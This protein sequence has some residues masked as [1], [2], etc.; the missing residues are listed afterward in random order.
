MATIAASGPLSFSTIKSIM[1]GPATTAIS[2][3]T[4]FAD[5]KYAQGVSGI[6][7]FIS[8][9]LNLGSFRSKAK[10]LTIGFLYRYYTSYF[11]DD[12]TYFEKNTEAS[13]GI[14]TDMSNLSI[15]VSGNTPAGAFISVEWFGYFYATSTGTWTF[16][17]VSDDASYMWIG[18]TALAGYTTTNALVQ[19]GG[20][21]GMQERSGTISMTSGQYYAIRIQF[22]QNEGVLG[23]NAS[24]TPPGGTRTYDFSSNVFYGLGT[25]TSFPGLSA[26]LIRSITSSDIDG[27]YYL[28]INGTST[29]TYCLMHNKWNGGGWM[30]L[31]KAT[32]GTT[33]PFSSTYWTD[34]NT[35]LNTANTNRND[36]DAKFDAMN[37]MMVKDVMAL[38]PDVGSTGGSISQTEAWSWLVNN[39]YTY[40]GGN[41]STLITGLSTTNSR[42][43]PVNP[44]PTTFA[45]FSGSIWSSQSPAKRHV[46]GGGSHISANRFVRW[47]FLWNENGQ[48]DFTSIDANG[49]IGMSDWGW[50][51]G[52][53]YGCCGTQALNRTMR[54]E[55]YGR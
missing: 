32:R 5:R 11:N 7:A 26:R 21:H 49:G 47:G 34:T 29:A 14:A 55:L 22:G 19:N 39:Y 51:A 43:S 41:R 50:S 4:Y 12:V 15:S 54:V 28:N 9:N 44:D 1:G 8:G 18:N 40:T 13:S 17:T 52:D 37:F 24:F 16:Y 38:W 25:Y 45:G 46:F 42:D 2:L 30:L 20:L 53:S 48:S 23:F 3:S 10:A 6:P 27:V 35:T 33:F 31:L 36:G